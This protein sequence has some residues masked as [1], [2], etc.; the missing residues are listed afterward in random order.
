[1]TNHMMDQSLSTEFKDPEK[2]KKILKD[3]LE[4]Y[5][6]LLSKNFKFEKIAD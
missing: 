3:G 4:W 6:V 2:I 5:M 1:M